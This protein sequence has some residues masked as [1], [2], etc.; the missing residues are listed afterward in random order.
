MLVALRGGPNDHLGGLARRG[1][2]GSVLILHQLPLGLSDAVPDLGHGGQNGLFLLVGAQFMEAVLAGQLNIHRKPVGQLTQPLGKERVGPG[3]GLGMD[4]AMKAVL[5]PQEGEGRYHLLSGAVG[6]D[7]H[8]GGE[9]QPLNI[10]A[11][12]ES[13]GQLR[14]LPWGEGRPGQ[15]VG[16]AVDAVGAVVDAAVGVQ[17]LQK[18]DTPAV[19]REG[20]A[21]PGGHGASHALAPPPVHPAGG[22]GGIILGRV[23]QNGQLIHQVHRTPPFGP[24]IYRTNVPVKRI[25]LELLFLTPFCNPHCFF[26]LQGV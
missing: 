7:P 25:V 14:Q 17:Y 11:P 24:I 19:G 10:V 21:A 5:L 23:R 4:I 20:V 26:L 22:A 13:G 2:P 16:P 18:G 1:K 15:V 8:R 3:D 9:K 12:V 6:A